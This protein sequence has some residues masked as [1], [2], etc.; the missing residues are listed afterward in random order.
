VAVQKPHSLLLSD[1]DAPVPKRQR[2]GTDSRAPCSG[3]EEARVMSMY[4]HR[5][6][7]QLSQLNADLSVLWPII[8]SKQFLNCREH[9]GGLISTA[10]LNGGNQQE[11][12][13]LIAVYEEL[14]RLKSTVEAM[15]GQHISVPMVSTATITVSTITDTFHVLQS[16]LDTLQQQLCRPPSA[17]EIKT[18]TSSVLDRLWAQSRL[19]AEEEMRTKLYMWRYKALDLKE[20]LRATIERRTSSAPGA[21]SAA[22]PPST[23]EAAAVPASNTS[24]TSAEDAKTLSVLTNA[25]EFVSSL[26]L[27]EV[28]NEPDSSNNN[29]RKERAMTETATALSDKIH[30]LQLAR[31]AGLVIPTPSHTISGAAQAPASF[32][33]LQSFQHQQPYRPHDGYDY[34]HRP[35]LEHYHAQSGQETPQPLQGREQAPSTVQT[36]V[37]APTSAFDPSTFMP[38]GA[39]AHLSVVLVLISY[40]PLCQTFQTLLTRRRKTNRYPSCCHRQTKLERRRATSAQPARSSRHL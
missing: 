13:P 28:V 21:A 9:G 25:L 1:L 22:P 15:F 34:L 11:Q 19:A 18:H 12:T 30:E 40:C 39:P 14:L 38:S 4:L 20:S 16:V 6:M 3:E 10:G 2:V 7:Q 23:T 36:I 27:L 32:L 8:Q 35:N 26:Y 24:S 37:A 5:S 31:R 17:D 29:L 33:P